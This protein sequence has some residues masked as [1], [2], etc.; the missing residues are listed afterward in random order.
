MAPRKRAHDATDATKSAAKKQKADVGDASA[1]SKVENPTTVN[2]QF[3][4]Q[5]Q[6]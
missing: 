2:D 3:K 6:N 1:F 4:L 5:V